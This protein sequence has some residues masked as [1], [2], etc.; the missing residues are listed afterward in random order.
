VIGSDTDSDGAGEPVMR[1]RKPNVGRTYPIETPQDSDEFGEARL[2]PQWQWHANPEAA[3]A[4]QF[5]Q[6]GALR[7]Y[8]V[9]T[10]ETY[11]NLWDLPNL[12]LQKFPA[13]EFSATA[14]V[15]LQTRLEGEKFGLVVMGLDY[16]YIGVARRGGKLYISEAKA[17]D[18][19]KGTAETEG[20]PTQLDG[21][22]FF[23]RVSVAKDAMC[24][25]AYSLDGKNFTRVGVPFKAREGRWIGAKVGFF[26]TRPAMFNDAGSADIDWFRFEK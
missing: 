5:P 6:R 18:A 16:S 17:K 19:D 13:E 24:T 23:L 25:F 2:A 9:L 12:L 20:V 8:S 10:P 26:F 11:R 15:K 7:M 4:L 21:L 3:W 22:D 1:F 14:K